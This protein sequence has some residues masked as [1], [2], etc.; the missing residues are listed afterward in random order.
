MLYR[1]RARVRRKTLSSSFCKLTLATRAGII[2]LS[3]A[4][5]LKFLFIVAPV[6]LLP[7]PSD[8]QTLFNSN[9]RAPILAHPL[10]PIQVDKRFG[11]PLQ[12]GREL[13]TGDIVTFSVDTGSPFD[14]DDSSITSVLETM[15]DPAQV[16]YATMHSDNLNDPMNNISAPL[17]ICL[18]LRIVFFIDT[19]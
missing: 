12:P 17:V 5:L 8:A 14:G 1:R 18:C 10:Y 16:H 13:Y 6:L 11:I 4:T 2:T 15:H 9:Q 19:S 3:P 7:F